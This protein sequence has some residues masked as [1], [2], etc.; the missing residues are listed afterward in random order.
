MSFSGAS[1]L[2]L[3]LIWKP[4]PSP[5]HQGG[6]KGP[7]LGKSF[8]WR[9]ILTPNPT[10]GH[11]A[12]LGPWFMARWCFSSLKPALRSPVLAGVVQIAPF[13]QR[14]PK[15]ALD[16]RGEGR[17]ERLVFIRSEGCG[18]ESARSAHPLTLSK[19]GR[20]RSWARGPEPSSA[21]L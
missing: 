4:P 18:S 7:A 10:F 16:T 5:N 20:D 13:P 15:C 11:L 21:L 1:Y 17:W 14:T 3:V 2:T 9:R 8:L 19:P 12:L 6:G